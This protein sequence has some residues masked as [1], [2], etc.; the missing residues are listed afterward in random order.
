VDNTAREETPAEYA[1]GVSSFAGCG[2]TKNY[3]LLIIYLCEHLKKLFPRRYTVILAAI[4][5]LSQE[6]ASVLTRNLIKT[7]RRVGCGRQ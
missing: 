5:F 4:L 1:A 2:N 6:S 7:G 3:Q